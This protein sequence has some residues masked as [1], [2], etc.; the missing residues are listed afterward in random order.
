MRNLVP[1][2]RIIVIILGVCAFAAFTVTAFAADSAS[3]RLLDEF[4]AGP[5]AEGEEIVFAARQLLL[6]GRQPQGISRYGAIM[7]P[8]Y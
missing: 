6:P 8:E 2:G 3:P 7:Q 1:A 4:L 5:M